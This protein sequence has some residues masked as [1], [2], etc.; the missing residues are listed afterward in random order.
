MLKKWWA[1]TSCLFILSCVVILCL[2][3][4]YPYSSRR[5]SFILFVV[6]FL[7]YPLIVPSEV[8]NLKLEMDT[9]E[10][11]DILI[12]FEKPLSGIAVSL[13]KIHPI[14]KKELEK[15]FGWPIDF[16]PTVVLIKESS[17]FSKI[18]GDS[19]IVAFALP[20]QNLIVIDCSRIGIHPF[21]LEIIFKHELCHLL[22][23]RYTT[24]GI[25]P[26][27]FDEGVCQW[28]TGGVAEILTDKKPSLNYAV[29]SRTLLRLD[30]LRD[31]FPEERMSVLLA[32]EESKSVV[33]FI[34]NTFGT[35]KIIEILDCM[36]NGESFEASLQKVL[37]MTP[38]ELEKQ[39]QTSLS[40]Y[41]SWFLFLSQNLYEI[42]F[43]A[44][45][46]AAIYAFIKVM[47]RRRKYIKYIDEEENR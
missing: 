7:L 36:K 44:M 24:A 22:L 29:F 38:Q 25:M 11:D 40:M 28:V 43:F 17:T 18:A 4:G 14:I 46:V 16:R 39:W 37:S 32:Y 3:S 1:I 10:R 2:M 35:G 8:P 34:G 31:R 33:E 27:W 30:G 45:A 5:L 9:E 15:T 23:Y 19:N 26:K 12:R 42:I 41:L 21:S 6:L 20:R 13:F 47:I